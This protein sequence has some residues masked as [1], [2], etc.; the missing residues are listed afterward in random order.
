MDLLDALPRTQLEHTPETDGR[1]QGCQTTAQ[2]T[3]V[4]VLQIIFY[5]YQNWPANVKRTSL[6]LQIQDFTAIDSARWY[7]NQ[8][9]QATSLF[10]DILRP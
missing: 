10:I 3:T 6:A 2:S 1:E 7:I 4:S 5:V 8:G 9:L